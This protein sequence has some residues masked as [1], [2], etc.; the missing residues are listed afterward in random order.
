MTYTDCY[1]INHTHHMSG[2]K[3][4]YSFRIIQCSSPIS[5]EYEYLEHMFKD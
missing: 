4:Y 5:H 1:R 3:Y 2:I